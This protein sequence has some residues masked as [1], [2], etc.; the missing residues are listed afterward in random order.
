MMGKIQI[1]LNDT[2][3]DGFIAHNVISFTDAV[4]CSTSNWI[5]TYVICNY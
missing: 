3:F 2:H 5:S 4:T 1:I